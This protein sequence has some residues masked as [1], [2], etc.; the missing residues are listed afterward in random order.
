M[1]KDRFVAI[2]DETESS[3]KMEESCHQKS[4]EIEVALNGMSKQ[5]WGFERTNHQCCQCG[6][7]KVKRENFRDAL[8]WKEFSLT[9]WCQRCQDNFFGGDE[10][11]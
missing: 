4:P 9:R 5:F 3:D 2:L 6:S 8:S 7:T 1:S 10:E 11:E